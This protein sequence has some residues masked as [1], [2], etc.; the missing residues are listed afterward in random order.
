MSWKEPDLEKDQ[1]FWARE[2][3]LGVTENS[4]WK[5]KDPPYPWDL[6]GAPFKAFAIHRLLWSSSGHQERWCLHSVIGEEGGPVLAIR[7]RKV[8]VNCKDIQ[9]N[10]KGVRIYTL[11]NN[12]P[13]VSNISSSVTCLWQANTSVDKYA[14]ISVWLIITKLGLYMIEHSSLS[15]GITQMEGIRFNRWDGLVFAVVAFNITW[16]VLLS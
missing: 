15:Y 11:T 7:F 9:V 16:L 6:P 4:R 12:F 5:V 14:W 3:C 13:F 8:S 10:Q 2:L 1:D